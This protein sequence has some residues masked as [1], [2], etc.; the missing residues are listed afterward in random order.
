MPSVFHCYWLP[1]LCATGVPFGPSLD[2]DCL[3][4]NGTLRATPT[5]P[6]GVLI[7]SAI[8]SLTAHGSCAIQARYSAHRIIFCVIP[9]LLRQGSTLLGISHYTVEW[10]DVRGGQLSM[11]LSC[12][13]SL[14]RDKALAMTCTELGR[15]RFSPKFL[16]LFRIS[17]ISNFSGSGLSRF[18]TRHTQTSK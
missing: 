17:I 6:H 5:L 4:E 12:R 1:A 9:T 3:T 8:T 10:K 18:I 7:R 16:L 13:H 2:P 15:P 11:T 14:L